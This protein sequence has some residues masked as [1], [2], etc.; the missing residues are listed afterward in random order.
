[1]TDENQEH[2]GETAERKFG[3]G[4]TE[5]KFGSEDVQKL[6]KMNHD[7]QDF[8]S[9]LK[10]ETSE[11][12]SEVD[13]L[14][15]ELSKSKT[16]DDL[17]EH[18]QRS[19]ESELTEQKTPQLDEGALLA[20]LEERVF[21]NMSKREQ[22]SLQESNWEQSKSLAKDQFGDGYVDYVT[23]KA[24]ELDISVKD[25]EQYAKT[26]PKVFMELLG[27]KTKPTSPTS[28]NINFPL[29]DNADAAEQEF[30]KVA[31]LQRNLN[32][33]E[34]REAHRLWKD[35]E[36]QAKHRMRILEGLNKR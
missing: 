29:S 31:R 23:N 21:D 8:I 7:A 36:W 6:M 2:S 28:S 22:Q 9:Q 5:A 33:E 30:Q 16:I 32:T 14:Q 4:E 13:K 17:M 35:P 20:K 19:F 24:K 15:E 3:E 25:M 34:G 1:M 10:T 26:S 27:G 18:Q 12:R 11:L